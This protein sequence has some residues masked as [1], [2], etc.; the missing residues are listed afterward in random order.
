[1]TRRDR[2]SACPANELT[3]QQID[4]PLSGLRNPAVLCRHHLRVPNGSW[5]AM[6]EEHASKL[7]NDGV[8]VEVRTRL[9]YA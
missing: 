6:V 5:Q 8:C 9:V 1:L 2:E 3:L 4:Y 7:A